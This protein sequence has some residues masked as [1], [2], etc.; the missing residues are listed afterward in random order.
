MNFTRRHFLGS[1]G[2]LGALSSLDYF[3]ALNALAQTAPSDYKALVCVYMYGGND[4]N[5]TI[6]PVDSRYADYARVRTTGDIG[7]AK[8]DG[9]QLLLPPGGG[10]AEF[11]LH[12]ALID[13]APLYTAG[14]MAVLFNVGTLIKKFAS[15]VE[16]QA[17][18]ND[19]KPLN[20][21]SHT[22]QQQAWQSGIASG[23]A[24][25]GWG[26]RIADKFPGINGS[27]PVPMVI[28]PS[29]GGLFMAGNTAGSLSIPE[30]GGF[31][32][33]GFGDSQGSFYGPAQKARYE[34]LAQLMA[35]DREAALVRGASN[36]TQG[37]LDASAVINT[38]VKSTTAQTAAFF[39]SSKSPALA[40]SIAS[41]FFQVA[42]IIESRSTIGPRRQIFFVQIE[43]F[44]THNNHIAQQQQLLQKLG[45]AL[46]AFQ[47][48]MDA[49]GM[50]NSVTTFTQSEFGRTLKPS[51]GSG[52]DHAWGN[53]HLVIGGA[54]KGG[55][56]YGSFPT[57]ALGTASP[58]D[59]S[60][61]GRWLPTTS[62]D[63]YAATLANWFGVSATDMK[64]VLPNIGNFATTDLGFMA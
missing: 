55:Q 49:I 9:A 11:G 29:G 42:K 37:A 51:A 52:S 13:L 57:L 10:A 17:S 18:T 27:I 47:D 26:G 28:S 19:A 59:V 58:D 14:K 63:Q 54:V 15:V 45:P 4:G 6:I 24:R 34:A 23:Y 20:L 22:D 30:N 38:A 1:I 43:G 16:Y 48:A 60:E 46:K 7:L 31:G 25:S 35:I 33:E 36:I 41:Q 50:G 12:P 5:N 61:E 62:S 3:G 64:Y 56:T 44:D 39:D 8:P 53:H 40:T 32:L 2:A 21:F